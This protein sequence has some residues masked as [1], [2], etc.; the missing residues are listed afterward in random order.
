MTGARADLGRLLGA[1]APPAVAAAAPGDARYHLLGVVTPRPAGAAREGLAL[2][3]VDGK[4]ARAFRVGTAVDDDNVL[5]SVNARG[6][7]LGPRSGTAAV[8]LTL[9]PPAPAATGTLPAAGSAPY[10]APAVRPFRPVGP[11]LARMPPVAAPVPA[12]EP[13]SN[14]SATE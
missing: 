10:A 6:A 9:A 4:P 7:T 11:P 3:V 1:D 5:Q 2:I 14:G 13:A 8:A 12:A